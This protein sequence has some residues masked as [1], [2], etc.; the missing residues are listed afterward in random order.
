MTVQSVQIHTT[1]LSEYSLKEE[2]VHSITHGVGILLSIA[3]LVV[4]VSFAAMSGDP[5]RIVSVSIFGSTLVLLYAASTVY[6]SV[7]SPGA[8]R[9]WQALD[10]ASIFVLIAGTYTPIVLVSL[11]GTIGWTLFGVVWGLA[12]MGVLFK[13]FLVERYQVASVFVYLGMGWLGI[14]VIK[15]TFD[16]LHMGGTTWLAAGGL[17]YTVGVLFYAWSRL[18]Y[19]HAIWHI[20]VMTGSV[21]HFFCVLFFVV[22]GE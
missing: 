14:L 17:A 16:A 19:N 2:L 3:A 8:K 5:Y 18:P 6:H 21:C 10:H 9:V 4:M 11:R 22:L 20:F 7:R 15:P 12:V 1:P 13:L